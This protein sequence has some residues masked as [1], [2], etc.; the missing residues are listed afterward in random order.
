MSHTSHPPFRPAYE[1]GTGDLSDAE[2]AT[3]VENLT[4]PAQR[5]RHYDHVR[6]AWVLLRDMS[7][8]AAT[9]RMVRLIR[10]FAAQ[11]GSAQ[12]YH[13]TITRA[14]MRFVAAHRRRTPEIEEFGAFAA[15]HPEL[16]D[17]RLPLA[18]YSEALLASPEA[19]ASWVE[20]DLRPLPADAE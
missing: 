16:F 12:T 8:T 10:D 2:L 9:E 5:F 13:D 18:Y 7:V 14:Y 15:A 11:H 17:K 4:L 20:P 6:L 3:A 19:R 1:S